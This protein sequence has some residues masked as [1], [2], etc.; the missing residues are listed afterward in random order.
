MFGWDTGELRRVNR[1]PVAL[2][3]VVD[4]SSE[5]LFSLTFAESPIR[6]GRYRSSHL[7]LRHPEIARCHGEICFQAGWACFRNH[8]WSK[9]SSIDQWR[10]ARGEAVW[11]AEDSVIELGPF[12]I[13]VSLCKPRMRDAERARKVTPLVLP[14]LPAPPPPGQGTGWRSMRSSWSKAEL[15]M[16]PRSATG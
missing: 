8:A 4:A 2:V 9:R 16:G 1:A 10:L 7:Q 12:R 11:L 15:V 3:T 6:I 13:D 14:G 5:R